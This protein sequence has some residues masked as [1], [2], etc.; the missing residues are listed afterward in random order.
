MNNLLPIDKAIT[1]H[2]YIALLILFWT[3]MHIMAHGFNW[4]AISTAPLAQLNAVLGTSYTENPNV[5][6]TA[7]LTIAGYTGTPARPCPLL[8][9]LISCPLRS[10]A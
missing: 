6:Q 4:Y 5:Y 7:Y 2:K 10:Q 1:F 9:A 3:I 8:A